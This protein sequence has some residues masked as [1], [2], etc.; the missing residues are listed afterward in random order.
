MKINKYFIFLALILTILK[1]VT[2]APALISLDQVYRGSLP[3]K[4]YAYL[5][6]VI[7]KLEDDYT[8]FLLIQARRNEQQ[9]FIDNIFS[10]PNLYISETEQYPGP[11]KNTWSSGRFGDE[12]ISI[13]QNYVKTDS[14]FYIAVY[15]EFKCNFL[16]DARLY[17]NYE[18]KEEK[19][20]TV[21][22]IANDVIKATFKSR[23]EFNELKINCVSTKMKP[24]RIYLALKDPS[25]SNTVASTPIY[26]N[27]Y[28]FLIQKGDEYYK[29]EADY[30]ILIE[31]RNYK[32]DLMF[33]I[34]Y[35]NEDVEL[36]EMG[37]M[38][39]SARENT[40][41]C[42]F[43]KI[44][45]Q[46][47]GKNIVVS[48][49]LYNGSGY[50]KIGG[51]EKCQDMKIIPNDKNTI[52]ILSDKSVLLTKKEFE[53]YGEVKEDQSNY[54]HFCFIASEETSYL[55][56]V[57]YQENAEVAQKL[58]YLLPG[59][60]NDDMLPEKT[61][62]KYTILY[63]QQ[64]QDI[65]IELKIKSGS[66]TLYSYYS[67][68][69]N[70]YLDQ[71][72]FEQMKSNG[73][74]LIKSSKVSYQKY[75][76]KIE[77]HFNK[78]LLVPTKDGKE[79]LIYA[80]IE[81]EGKRDCLY[82]LFFD[83]I[84]STVSMKP[85]VIY[86][87]VITE[88]EID[89]Y[90]IRVPDE[91]TKN[92]AVI[93]SQSTGNTKLRFVRFIS[94]KGEIT[95]D[96]GE[97]FNKNYMPN[98]IEIKADE[99]GTNNLKGTFEF[100]VIG[101]S[102]SS[103]NIYYYTFDDN[104]S[105]KL[106]HKTISMPLVR[107]NII[108]DYIKQNHNI[109][110]YS[111]DNSNVGSEK[112][113]LFI[114]IDYPQ[115]AHYSLYVFKDLDD[116]IYENDKVKGYLWKSQYYN[117]I[118]IEKT[119][120]N[121]IVG[122]LYIM[123]FVDRANDVNSNIVYRKENSESLF[124]LAITDESTPLT[125]I[126][127]VEFRQVLTKKRKYQTF[128]YN[129]QNRDEA[130]TLSISVPNSKLK[131]GLKLQD[132]NYIYEKTIGGNYYLKIKK[133][134]LSMYCPSTDMCNIEISVEAIV[135]YDLDFEISLLCKGSQNS[136]VYLNKNGIIEKRKILNDEKQYFVIDANPSVGM[137]L[138]INA[139]F[140]YG[141]GVLFAKIYTDKGP[142]EKSIFPSEFERDYSS[143]YMVNEE[144]S[145]LNIPYE[146]LKNY[147]PCKILIT[148]VGEFEYLGKNEG[149][150]T[151]SVSNI[152]DDIFP[153][154]NYRLYATKG[155]IKYYRFVIKGLKK[156]LSIS[157][158]NKEVDA[159]MYLNYATMNKETND[160]QWRSEG[161]YNEYIDLSVD[162]PFFVSRKIN[163]VEGEYY[164][165]IR[166]F[167]D[168]YFNLFISDSN[169]K[170]MTITEDFPGTCTCEKE[171]DYCY[172]R[173]EN[174]NSPEI[175]QV[176]EQEMIF[177]FEF[178]YGAADIYAT[179]FD[180]GNN[181]MIFQYLPN[182]YRKDYKSLYSEQFLRIK[183]KP[184]DPKYTL[185]SVIILSAQCRAKSMF[186]FNVRP[187]LKS[188]EILE[189]YGG[190]LHLEMNRDNV[191]F[192]NENSEQTIKLLLYSTAN[193][194][195]GYEAKALSGAA[196][197]H[198][199]INNEDNADKE[200][201]N[202]V[203]GYKHLTKFSVD[204]KDS[205]SYYD[206]LDSGNTFRQNLFF[207]LKAKKDCLFSIHLHY[208]QDT[209]NIPM[210]KQTQAKFISGELFAYIELLKE[211]DEIILNIDKMHPDSKYAVYAKTNIVNSI[212]FKSTFSYSAPSENNY[213]IRA[214]TNNYSPSLTIKIKNV[215]KELYASNKKVVTLFTIRATNEK[216]M[217]DKLNMIAYPNV[218]HLNR[219]I[220]Q[221]KKY[222]YSSITTQ[223]LDRTVFTFKPQ[224]EKDN[225]LIVEL[226]ACKG[227]IGYTFTNNIDKS[228][229]D[230][231]LDIKGKT[232]ILSRIQRD[233]EYY[234]SVFGLKEDEMVFAPKINSTCDLDFLLY[235]YTAQEDFFSILNN[236]YR[237]L[238][239]EIKSPG[240]V[241]INVPS[242]EIEVD[243]KTINKKD[244]L[245]MSVVISDVRAEFD[246]MGSICF[247]SKRI[248][249]VEA[250]NLYFNYSININKNEG[251]IEIDKLNP[252]KQ[253]YINVLVSNTKTGQLMTFVPLELMAYKKVPKNIII[254]ILSVGIVL[255]LFVLFYYYRKLRIAKAIVNYE[256]N[257]IKKMGS[258]PKSITELKK[259][260]EIKN[261]QAKEKYNSLTEDSGE[262]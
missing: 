121:Y 138:R 86:S 242:L 190:I 203:K 33:W 181:G 234:L 107:G 162:D 23:K 68:E 37:P 255:L 10:D 262:I 81:C 230:L 261:K 146:V 113:D 66:P 34:S 58:N 119:D 40:G 163:S 180:N 5:K 63:L 72:K 49:S 62:T 213:D 216:S 14:A 193:L 36:N 238:S 31:N 118:H 123:V 64:S 179:L 59:I 183:L 89:K 116:F 202:S 114:Y 85:K 53:K 217:N 2:S 240:S 42:Y 50:L 54:L 100:Q 82:E 166:A 147:L 173:Y 168:T 69:D 99:L 239:Y 226:S 189:N 87:N 77:K 75:E 111:Y 139:I 57:Y 158:T 126:E 161:S 252:T 96:N 61:L 109:K 171:G 70:D 84:G 221:A 26:I 67:Y 209:L 231:S 175:A 170:I 152:V 188:Y 206:L 29:T 249:L 28:S 20:Y 194:P 48:T 220:P 254:T 144:I 97:R 73:T 256:S 195:I 4:G 159:Y 186:D 177:Y 222:I 79:C 198:C 11:K 94:S 244:D 117:Y 112:T 182:L 122:N 140:T 8:K 155:E 210:S 98:I 12:I 24:F 102:F 52:P 245:K 165:A 212:N 27:G 247:L 76:I 225:L 258:I 127:G 157:M 9:D 7:P 6:L 30:E 145:V 93:L 201:G 129:H 95:L 32:Q 104:G 83:H 172:F 204:E 150:Y 197:V 259:I 141:R 257:D 232:I 124:S 108:Q 192:I 200:A 250:N 21:S 149:E 74:S 88:N 110:V 44:D 191:F 13:N 223:Q 135:P 134:D 241:V 208:T 22:M 167:K 90:E 35:D 176:I 25:S 106:D 178:T 260:Q 160:F 136:I 133:K 60:G 78:C 143:D 233:A 228:N 128:F 227:N 187:L 41:T 115:D 185:N 47:Q 45:K 71:E 164:L 169:V 16:L 120:E 1:V 19:A 224:E 218:D 205:T 153:N 207:E 125:L 237:D 46:H 15:C 235:Y 214:T 251:K 219:I 130:F 151:L 243:K 105:N 154:K 229:E 3:D 253:Y 199:Y 211:Y 38:F 39:N 236:Q 101:N 131:L 56:K 91:D 51:W 80:V 174:I 248:E 103:Y 137:D 92:L 132:K 43:F 142:I 215:P 184:G 55:I 148:V 17:K 156:R 65:R 246:Y 18:M 196:E